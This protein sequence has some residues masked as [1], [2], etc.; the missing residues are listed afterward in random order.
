MKKILYILLVIAFVQTGFAQN[1]KNQFHQEMSLIDKADENYRDGAYLEALYHY[2]KAFKLDSTELNTLFQIAL[3]HFELKNFK[4]CQQVLSKIDIGKKAGLEPLFKKYYYNALCLKNQGKYDDAFIEMRQFY[5]YNKDKKN[6]IH[7]HA[8]A[9][10][11]TIQKIVNGGL[12][13]DDKLKISQLPNQLNSNES[14]FSPILLDDTTIIFSSYVHDTSDKNNVVQPYIASIFDKRIKNVKPFKFLSDSILNEIKSVGNVSFNEDTT[15]LYFTGIDS[16]TGFTAVFRCDGSMNNWSEPIMMPS[17]INTSKANTTQLQHLLIDNKEYYLF[18]SDRAKGK[19]GMD[20]WFTEVKRGKIKKPKNIKKVN[21]P[22]TEITPFYDKEYKILYLSSNWKDNI[23]GLDI[24]KAPGTSL[25]KI[26]A[27]QNMGTPIN[28]PYNELYYYKHDESRA[29]YASNQLDNYTYADTFP[30]CNDI[31]MA[32][33]PIDSLPYKE[34]KKIEFCP[35]EQNL[36]AESTISLYFPNDYPNPRS[37]DTSTHESYLVSHLKYNELFPT[38]VK[39]AKKKN[40]RPKQEIEDEL[41]EFFVDHVNAGLEELKEF[42]DVILQQL[43][44]GKDIEVTVKGYASSLAKSDYNERLTKRRIQSFVNYLED[45]KRGVFKKYL[46]NKAKNN[47]KLIIH[48]IPFGEE[49]ADKS[50]SDNADDVS[51]SMYSVEAGLERKI[52]IIS[53]KAIDRNPKLILYPDST[54]HKSIYSDSVQT[55]NHTVTI[56]NGLETGIQFHGIQLHLDTTL[57]DSICTCKNRIEVKK[58]PSVLAA[59]QEADFEF[60]TLPAKDKAKVDPI[61]ELIY[62][63]KDKRK[64]YRYKIHIHLQD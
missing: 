49:K 23:G 5:K 41:K 20:I 62:L 8:K 54:I 31:Y 35:E 30:C 4:Q 25:K 26:A 9:Q 48:R 16:L 17:P 56:K 60:N 14:E 33:S 47:A 13:N 58:A 3:C 53:A 42:T 39:G 59:C 21:S 29:Y 34:E 24:F 52:E 1:F 27:P 64:E 38:Y 22:G 61:I 44:E 40:K 55:I 18:A 36:L 11:K 50:V 7:K 15:H 45:Y 57:S 2:E 43:N 32:V 19:G 63:S 37:R 51:H 46:N 6:P 10:V 12:A 28:T